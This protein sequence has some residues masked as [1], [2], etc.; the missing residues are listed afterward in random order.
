MNSKPS[1]ANGIKKYKKKAKT[2]KSYG[3]YV[4][5]LLKTIYPEFNLSS[6]AVLTID[7]MINDIFERLASEAAH[8][9][10]YRKSRTLQE[11]DF[12]SAV[13]LIYTGDLANYAVS[14]GAKA[15]EKCNT[16]F[17]NKQ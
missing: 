16:K 4:K 9:C 8:L 6:K 1:D 11:R 7:S 3:R 2:S 15:V 5:R 14:E 17:T 13:R 12:K 10:R